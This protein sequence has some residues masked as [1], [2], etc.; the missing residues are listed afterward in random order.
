MTPTTTPKRTVTHNGKVCDAEV[1]PFGAAEPWT[2]ITAVDGSEIKLRV[3]VKE[4]LR[5]VG[6]YDGQGDPVY[7]VNSATVYS[8]LSAEHLRRDAQVKGMVN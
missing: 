7:V 1:V 3:V 2:V 5:L 4:V 6:E 8:V